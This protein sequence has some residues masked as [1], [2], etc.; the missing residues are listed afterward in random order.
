MR[1][2]ECGNEMANEFKVKNGL[3][4]G[5]QIIVD[6][7][8]NWV[9][10]DVPRSVNLSGG[11]LN[12]VPYQTAA[13]TTGFVAAPTT[14]NTY[15][16][17]NGSTL[18]WGPAIATAIPWVKKTAAYTAVAGD[19]IIG[20]T[21]A[22][23]FTITLPAAATAGDTIEF[24]DGNSWATNNL[25]I[26]RNGLTIEGAA[27][28]VAFDVKGITVQFIY[29]GSTW[30]VTTTLGAKGAQGLTGTGVT[31]RVT[32]IVID[33]DG[34][35]ITAGV[36]GEVVV[37]FPGTISSWTILGNAAGTITVDVS[38][39]SYANFPTFTASG[40]TSPS[41]SASQKNTSGIN[42]T[43]FTTVTTGDILRF[44]VSGTIATVTRVTIAL[45]I[46]P[47]V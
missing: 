40:G 15:L 10:P 32:N 23:P 4:V 36:K 41:L 45:L 39:A 21:T 28:D 5:T 35:V 37:D 30:Q 9:G 19:R 2:V 47:S 18:V 27:N 1:F 25:T 31:T 46:I 20:D 22:G 43:G 29:D 8:G 42:W 38:K 44:T 3:A 12:R 7:A 26:A 24:T 6:S 11:A 17:Y 34:A 14:N 16:Q 33:N 13:N